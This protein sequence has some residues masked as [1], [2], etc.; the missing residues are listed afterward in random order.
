MI[1]PLIWLCT[2]TVAIGVTVPS[3]LSVIGMSP[4][5]ALATTTGMGP[6]P[7][8]RPPAGARAAFEGVRSQARRT[9]RPRTPRINA[10]RGAV[11]TFPQRRA[12][13]EPGAIGERSRLVSFMSLDGR[14]QSVL[15]AG[16]CD[17][18]AWRLSPKKQGYGTTRPWDMPGLLQWTGKEVQR[19]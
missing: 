8:K 10:Q 1:W 17:S 13:P 5:R 7:A 9:N 14:V 4:D 15:R 18:S 16:R 2:V 12:G 6:P 3:P 19:I 11:R